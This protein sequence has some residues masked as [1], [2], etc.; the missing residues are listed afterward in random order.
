MNEQPQEGQLHGI[1]LRLDPQGILIAPHEE[2]GLQWGYTIIDRDKVP[3][4][5]IDGNWVDVVPV[6]VWSQM[7]SNWDD[8]SS[9][10]NDLFSDHP[11]YL[12]YP[13]VKKL[14]S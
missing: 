12:E 10:A 2:G 1:G 7:L 8:I 11:G 14:C 9:F 13:E 4:M 6:G 3:T 5:Y